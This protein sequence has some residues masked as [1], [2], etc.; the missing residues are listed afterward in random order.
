[1]SDKLK[2]VYHPH[3]PG[4]SYEVPEADA[5]GWKEQGWRFTESA[6]PVPV[7]PVEG[8]ATK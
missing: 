7:A 2:T 8:P 4:V 5:Q 1:M 3:L 6:T